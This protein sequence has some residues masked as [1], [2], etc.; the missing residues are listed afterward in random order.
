MTRS[1]N[2]DFPPTWIGSLSRC[3]PEDINR[4]RGTSTF[5]PAITN[6]EYLVNHEEEYMVSESVP[7]IG[8]RNQLPEVPNTRPQDGRL[9][10]GT[11]GEIPRQSPRQ[12]SCGI[13]QEEE[14][15]C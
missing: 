7:F 11:Q 1:R 15:E 3:Y 12:K 8:R 9:G 14:A 5:L 4:Q 2:P 10:N 6:I 13:H